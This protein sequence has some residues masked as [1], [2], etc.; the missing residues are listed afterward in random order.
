MF[1]QAVANV[2]PHACSS[3]CV[4]LTL[5]AAHYHLHCRRSILADDLDLM[6]SHWEGISEEAKDFV[7]MLLNKVQ[8]ML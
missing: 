6:H 1:Q 2:Q 4:E 7:K 5:H 8:S 3:W